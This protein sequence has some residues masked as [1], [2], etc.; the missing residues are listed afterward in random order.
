M[1]KSQAREQFLAVNCPASIA[2]L[3]VFRGQF[4]G[5]LGRIVAGATQASAKY[6][7]AASSLRDLPGWPEAIKFD[8][9]RVANDIEINVVP[10]MDAL[11]LAG[12]VEEVA[13]IS[14]GGKS[15][16]KGPATDRV[17]KYLDL[18]PL[19]TECN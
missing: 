13:S 7:R 1:T 14:D 4:S 6:S 17:L 3:D 15:V 11:A 16:S 10:T 12:S 19:F 9:A 18:G 5:D 8:I 2:L